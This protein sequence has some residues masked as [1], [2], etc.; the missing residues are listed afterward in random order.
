MDSKSINFCANFLANLVSEGKKTS[1]GFKKVHLNGCANALNDH[2]KINRTADQIANHLKTLKK[3]IPELTTS[4]TSVLL[5]G[6]KLISSLLLIMNTT[7]IILRM[8]K[9]SV[10]TGQ[11]V[12]T[13]QEQFSVD[14][15]DNSHKD[16]MTPNES[17]TSSGNKPSKRAKKDDSVVDGLVGAIDRGTETLASLAEVIKEVAAAKTTPEGLFEE[18]DNL[19]APHFFLPKKSVGSS[20]SRRPT[21][22]SSPPLALEPSRTVG[23]LRVVLSVS[24]PPALAAGIAGL[25]AARLAGWL[26]ASR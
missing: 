7:Q 5:V 12:R 24:F 11:F 26:A 21:L 19:P 15:C 14:M 18:V 4:R 2:F 9:I 23:S 17:G 16:G 22:E 10:A 8:E 25:E 1:T 6:M 13:S 3:N 20:S